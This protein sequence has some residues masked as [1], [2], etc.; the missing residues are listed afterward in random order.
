MPPASISYLRKD[1]GKDLSS[2]RITYAASVCMHIFKNLAVVWELVSMKV[3]KTEFQTLIA[4]PE[5][6]TQ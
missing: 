6:P 5:V 4:S 1:V 2:A 3:V